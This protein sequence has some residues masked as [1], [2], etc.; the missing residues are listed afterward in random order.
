MR[1][2]RQPAFKIIGTPKCFHDTG[3][4][5]RSIERPQRLRVYGEKDAGSRT[6]TQKLF[7]IIGQSGIA[8]AQNSKL[9]LKPSETNSP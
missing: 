5:I 9:T 7:T 3:G 2:V 6:N 4:S 1:R 8:H